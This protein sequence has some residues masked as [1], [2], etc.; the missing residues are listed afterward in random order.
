MAR[1]PASVRRVF[2]AA[3]GRRV[4]ATNP[5]ASRRLTP[6][7]ARSPA[8]RP[9]HPREAVAS[10][11]VAGPGAPEAAGA[12]SSSRATGAADAAG[13][14]R[15]GSGP[16]LD[17]GWPVAHGIPPPAVLHHT[18]SPNPAART[19]TSSVARASA[20]RTRRF[21]S[22]SGLAQ[23]PALN[24]FPS[25]DSSRDT[26]SVRAPASSSTTSARRSSSGGRTIG[27]AFAGRTTGSGTGIGG[28][29]ATGP[30]SGSAAGSSSS[31]AAV[32]GGALSPAG[33]VRVHSALNTDAGSGG[34]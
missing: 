12:A 19:A 6:D 5:G 13:V 21:A 14:C 3:A 34:R 11:D 29:A 7:Q 33:A 16:A 2:L 32:P 27:G 18:P 8:H 4:A 9:V 1:T 30:A 23:T 20:V 15:P 22:G 26:G 25:G 31:S 10:P 17:A 24:A 28:V